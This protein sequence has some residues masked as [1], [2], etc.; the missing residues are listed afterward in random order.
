MVF[1]SYF[2][3]FVYLCD[4]QC[5]KWSFFSSFGL[6]FSSCQISSRFL[7]SFIFTLGYIT[8][9]T[10]INV[11][12]YFFLFLLLSE[13]GGVSLGQYNFYDTL[14]FKVSNPGV[15]TWLG[16]CHAVKDV[17]CSSS[18]QCKCTRRKMPTLKTKAFT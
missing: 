2:I 8:F 4:N 16:S 12:V 1:M 5:L 14:Q 18:W 15:A 7:S 3:R 9:M 11:Y 17:R 13:G 10:H 6:C